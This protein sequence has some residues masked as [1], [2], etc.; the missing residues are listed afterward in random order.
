[1]KS[2]RSPVDLSYE[3]AVF[4]VRYELDSYI[5]VLLIPKTSSG[6]VTFLT[7]I[8]EVLIRISADI[9]YPDFGFSWFFSVSPKK[10]Q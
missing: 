2:Q 5:R 4:P 3:D 7:S 6:G 8:R 10:M 1:M 9:N